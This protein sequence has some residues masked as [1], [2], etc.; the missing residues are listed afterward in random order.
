[1][2]FALSLGLVHFFWRYILLCFPG[3]ISRDYLTLNSLVFVCCFMTSGLEELMG[4]VSV[5]NEISETPSTVSAND[6]YHHFVFGSKCVCFS[7][8]VDA[9]L[10]TN[11]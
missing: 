2:F 10:L 1:M 3:N 11:M 9:S 4:H 7:L 5:K 8:S 6:W